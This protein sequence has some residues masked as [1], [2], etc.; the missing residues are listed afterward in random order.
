VSVKRIKRTFV[1][2]ESVDY[3]DVINEA[4]RDVRRARAKVVD[5]ESYILYYRSVEAF[6]NILIPRLVDPEVWELLEKA[7]VRSKDGTFTEENIKA[8]DRAVRI[9]LEKLDKNRVLIRGEF[10]EEEEM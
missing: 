2:Y 8:L 3:T 6:V 4:L 10:Y 1:P 9:Q 5:V 7:R